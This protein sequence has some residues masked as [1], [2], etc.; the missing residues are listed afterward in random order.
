MIQI[1]TNKA[2]A[3]EL[4]QVAGSFC[5]QE[6]SHENQSGRDGGIIK[7]RMIGILGKHIGASGAGC[8]YG[9]TS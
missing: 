3:G 7:G 9:K 5:V 4:A 1:D 6:H 2:S 8:H